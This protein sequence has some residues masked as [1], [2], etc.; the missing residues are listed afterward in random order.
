MWLLPYA[1]YSQSTEK[2]QAIGAFALNFLYKKVNV[3]SDSPETR[4]RRKNTRK[5]S[6]AYHKKRKA[7][8]DA[9]TIT[10][11]GKT[12]HLHLKFSESDF[13]VFDIETTGGNPERNG[14]TEICA[15]RYSRGEITDHF[16][17][18]VNPQIP[19][20]PI[21]RRMTG[22]TNK[23]VKDAPLIDE[24]M[25][26]F[27]EFVGQDILV[28]HNTIGDMKF[29]RYF[30][31][32]VSG[33]MLSNYY[34][35]THLLVEKLVAEAPD[36]SL[37][38]LG[39]YFDLAS[40]KQLHR[41]EADAYLT[42]ELFKVLIEKLEQKKI[43]QSV[44]AIRLQGDYE[45]GMRLGWSISKNEI[46]QLPEEPGVYFLKNRQ[47]KTVHLA[48]SAN[49]RSD[50]KKLSNL[51]SLPKQLMKAVL[52]SNKI[53]YEKTASMVEASFIEGR[54]LSKLKLRFDTAV[55]QQ[56]CA[57]FIYLKLSDH[58]Y[59]L[60]VGILEESV[61]FAIGP[62]KNNREA[63]DFCEAV[64][65][66]VDVK[67][68]KR[69][70]KLDLK[71][72]AALLQ[73]LQTHYTKPPG[74]VERTLQNLSL[75]F[76]DSKHRQQVK[77][78]KNIQMPKQLKPLESYGGVIAQEFAPGKTRLVAISGVRVAD[79]I[80]VDQDLA[81]VVDDATILLR[82][83]KEIQIGQ[84]SFRKQF[85]MLTAEHANFLNRSVWWLYFGERNSS[86]EVISEEQLL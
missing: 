3:L 64:A 82:L 13:I 61:V 7:R 11:S 67:A 72:G 23:M 16:E 56:R 9:L 54:E 42:L 80:V 59:H 24:V 57:Q 63:T 34:L 5:K 10:A 35:C 17:S 36:K 65:T 66:I 73:V 85:D 81:G 69:G 30:S 47:N 21:V 62:V 77:E 68:T 20:P 15:I 78:L 48:A 26:R 50:L 58:N 86:L 44:A 75:R 4:P 14:I 12:A 28:S 6:A 45:S 41:A 70:V 43:T 31:Q 84:N 52:S 18:L 1:C 33:K 29:L 39:E 25:P 71:Q 55:W 51:S 27:I 76:S 37:K 22:I 2:N 79:P 40:D 53:E 74:L 60:G 38:G 83:R 32:Q 8:K 49:I 46:N 19:I